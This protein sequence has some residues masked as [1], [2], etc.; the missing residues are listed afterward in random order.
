MD[1][2]FHRKYDATSFDCF[3]EAATSWNEDKRARVLDCTWR[4]RWFG[5]LA[6]NCVSMVVKMNRAACFSVE[7]AGK[8]SG[9]V[10]I[11]I[12]EDES[13]IAEGLKFNF[14]Q[15]GYDAIVAGDGVSALK[16]LF[17]SLFG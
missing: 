4:K 2:G 8:G 10:K 16:V 9:S 15:E 13:P 7:L 17:R 11:L 6:E 5:N 1:A 3:F 12:V 14:E